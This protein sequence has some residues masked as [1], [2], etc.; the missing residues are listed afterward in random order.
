MQNV[1]TQVAHTPITT[2]ILMERDK[3]MRDFLRYTVQDKYYLQYF[4]QGLVNAKRQEELSIVQVIPQDNNQFPQGATT[5][6]YKAVKVVHEVN[7]TIA[8]AT[9]DLMETA[10]VFTAYNTS[11][12]PILANRFDLLI[13]T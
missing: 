7:L 12:W 5:M 3:Q 4:Y 2:G 6:R 10:Y 8:S 11:T 9:L 13:E 1:Y